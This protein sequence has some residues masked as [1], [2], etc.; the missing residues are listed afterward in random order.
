[1]KHLRLPLLQAT[2]L[3]WDLLPWCR[4]SRQSSWVETNISYGDNASFFSRTQHLVLA[5]IK[6]A[7]SRLIQ[8]MTNS[9]VF[10]SEKIGFGISWNRKR[11]LTF[12][13]METICMKCQIRFSWKNEIYFKMSNLY[14]DGSACT[15]WT[16]TSVVWSEPSLIAGARVISGFNK[17]SCAMSLL[18]ASGQ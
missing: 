14:K 6:R 4:H 15:L 9:I 18:Y 13:A 10:I 11:D 7:L 8:Q 12:H 2:A 1:M 3:A 17:T 5:G 16:W